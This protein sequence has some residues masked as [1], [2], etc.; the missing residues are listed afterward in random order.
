MQE[1]ERGGG[2]MRRQRAPS[3]KPDDLLTTEEAAALLSERSG[4]PVSPRY[5]RTLAGR[6]GKLTPV[7]ID[8]RTNLYRRAEVEAITVRERPHRKRRDGSGA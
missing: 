3:G 1:N 4:H 7:P 5:V 2:A 6:Y 8:K